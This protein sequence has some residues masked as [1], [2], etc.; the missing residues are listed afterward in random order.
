MTNWQTR[1]LSEVAHVYDGTHQTPT[2]VE[3]GVA[4]YSVE[5][6][7]SN[8][9]KN[10]KYIAT[11]VYEKEIHRV[12]IE[13]G[14][15]LMTRIG[16]IGTARYIDWTP[17]A[18]FYVSLT[19]IKPSDINGKF[20][21]Y[22]INSHYFQKELWKRSLTVAFPYKI[23]LGDIGKCELLI[24]EKPEQERI[25]QVLEVWDEYIE[26][27]KQKIALKEQLRKGLIQQLLTG[28]YHLPGF[29]KNNWR[30]T[31]LGLIADIKTGKKDNQNKVA[32]GQFP[33]FVRSPFIERIDSYS[34]DGEAILIPGEGN[35]GKIFHYINGK[36]DYH[37]RVYKISDFNKDASG[38]FIY[39]YFIK[40]FAKQARQDSVKATVDSLRL[41]TFKN[42]VIN[43]PIR[44]EQ[45]AIVNVLDNITDQVT[46][47]CRKKYH[48]TRQKKYL[49]K[50]LITGKI[51]TPENLTLK[52]MK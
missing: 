37:Q 51:R 18:S 35:V 6:V 2:Y 26:K 44:A 28:K 10:T 21:S 39:Y 32:D 1:R 5:Q 52:G 7:T 11:D 38:R 16:D 48:L 22:V 4:F 13:K 41:P 29:N 49:L 8:N 36:F 45:D 43:L 31:K 12:K 14:D 47:L 27:L 17:Q 33:F 9:F 3:Q 40:N 42:F 34:Y 23:N 30:Q 19:L 24:P 46:E 25:V 15:V 20:L 50:N